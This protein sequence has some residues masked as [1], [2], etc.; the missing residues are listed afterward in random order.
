ME[1]NGYMMEKMDIFGVGR[2]NQLLRMI[3]L[4]M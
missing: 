1:R 2:E 4:R 3:L